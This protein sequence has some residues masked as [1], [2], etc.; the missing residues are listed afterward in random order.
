[1]GEYIKLKNLPP[2]KMAKPNKTRTIT[3]PID[4]YGFMDINFIG[5]SG[6]F[7]HYPYYLFANEGTMEGNDSFKDKI[8]LIAAYAATGIATDEKQ[9]PYG[10]TF[11]IEHHANALN[12]ILNQDFLYKLSDLQNIIIMLCIA[13][14]LGILVPKLSILASLIITLA[15]AIAYGIASYLLFD[16]LSI[17]TAF[18]TPLIQTALTYSLLVTYRVINEQQEK[19][20]IRQTF[21]KFVSKSV[22]DELLKDPSKVKL[23]LVIYFLEGFYVLRWN[24]WIYRNGRSGI[25]EDN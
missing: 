12:T 21:S 16:Y 15:L 4:R 6:S 14:L 2:E 10:A 20:Y 5:G 18:A 1:M 23:G 22:V 3:I 25:D 17:I 24:C 19:K 7:Q 13:I 11:G 8:L 9:S